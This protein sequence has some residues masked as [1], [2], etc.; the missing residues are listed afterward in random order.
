MIEKLTLHIL[1][2]QIWIFLK[3]FEENDVAHCELHS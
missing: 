3:C 1:N 2:P